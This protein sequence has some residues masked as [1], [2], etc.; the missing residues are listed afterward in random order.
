MRG[1]GSECFSTPGRNI[2][3]MLG[4]SLGSPLTSWFYQRAQVDGGGS[5]PKKGGWWRGETGSRVHSPMST[6]ADGELRVDA[7]RF[8]ADLLHVLDV[9]TGIDAR[10][11][12]GST[13]SAQFEHARTE[14]A[15]EGAIVRDEDHGAFEV[16]QG[17]DQH[18]LG[19]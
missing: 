9:G 3:F 14:A 13:L 6:E 7:G 8:V 18:F 11:A 12:I 15:Q 16:F 19:G 5:L 2:G 4:C 1:L 10:R 17:I